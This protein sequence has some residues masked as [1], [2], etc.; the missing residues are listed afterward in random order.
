MILE[1]LLDREIDITR[2][3]S[4]CNPIEYHKTYKK[5]ISAPESLTD[6]EWKIVEDVTHEFYSL[7]QKHGFV[8]RVD[9]RLR[10]GTIKVIKNLIIKLWVVH[11]YRRPS[12]V[13]KLRANRSK[14]VEKKKIHPNTFPRMIRMIEAGKSPKSNA[15][16][17]LELFRSV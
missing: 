6:D 7:L 17:Y 16:H 14:L 2:A 5:L 3:F 8:K 15:K 12:L 10:K 9:M 4:Y 1:S 13:D 11:E